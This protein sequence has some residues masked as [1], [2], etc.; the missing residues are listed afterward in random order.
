MNKKPLVIY[1]ANCTDGLA[2]AW[3]FWQA[4]EDTMEYFPGV[5]GQPIPDIADRVVYLVDFSY[6]RE[7]IADMCQWATS[8]AVLDHHRTALDDLDGLD[9]EH[10][11]LD[12]SHCTITKSGA[13]IA[14]DYVMNGLSSKEEYR[15]PPLFLQHVQDRDLWNFQLPLTKEI[16]RG[17]TNETLTLTTIDI[18]MQMSKTDLEYI[19]SLGKNILISEMTMIK[20]IVKECSRKLSLPI[21]VDTFAELVLISA[22][23]ALFSEMGDYVGSDRDVSGVIMYYDTATHRV[24]G[25]RSNKEHGVDVGRIASY[26]SGGGHKNAAGFKVTRLHWLAQL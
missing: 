26:Y 16:I 7:Q 22:P 17:A 6:K 12:L 5:Y 15:A 21:S 8:V 4:Y 25:L 14:W 19:A 2:A 24:F 1:H 23:G 13:G 10:D 18:Y 9:L 11:N 3:C 20:G